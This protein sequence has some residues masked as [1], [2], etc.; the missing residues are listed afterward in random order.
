MQKE[1]N[2]GEYEDN[3]LRQLSDLR[4]K[5]SEANKQRYS[6]DSKKRLMT[7]AKK[8]MNTAFI[9]SLAEFEKKFG[10]LWGFNSGVAYTKDEE[11]LKGEL[12]KLG[13]TEDIFHAW[14]TEVRTNVLHNG[15]NQLRALEQEIAQ[16]TIKWD[17]YSFVPIVKQDTKEIS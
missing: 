13:M 2:M 10:F 8:K 7:I 12:A 17:R 6:D 14:W 5:T 1:S 11:W 3:K 15:N 16:Y 4:K 9:G